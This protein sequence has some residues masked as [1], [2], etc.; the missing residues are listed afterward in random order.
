MNDPFIT[1]NSIAKVGDRVSEA[2]GIFV[3]DVLIQGALEQALAELRM[4]PYLLDYVFYSLREDTLTSKKYG[5][6]EIAQAKAWFLQNNIP[7]VMDFGMTPP[8]ASMV[9]VSLVESS[10]AETTLGD[11]HYE[12]I[13]GV[14]PT[15]EP[16]AGPFAV[17]AYN[18]TTG[19]VTVPDSVASQVLIVPGMTLVDSVGRLFTIKETVDR[20]NFVIDAGIVTDLGNA[21]I[22]GAPPRLTQRLESVAFKETYRIGCHYHGEPRGLIWLHSIVVWCLLARRQELLEGRGFERSIISSTPFAKDERW[23]LAEKMWTRFI[24]LTGYVRQ[25]WMKGLDDRIYSA[26]MDDTGPDTGLKV[27]SPNNVSPNYK[28]DLGQQDPEWLAQDG[29]SFLGED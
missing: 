16:L 15:W 21:F 27:S 17:V 1:T 25:F 24:N 12:T 13:E 9:S 26:G 14:S 2:K 3:S 8:E 29:I 5:T 22:K 11:V 20:A 23:G 4:Y 18:P 19:T 10:E 28:A 6:Q 7:V